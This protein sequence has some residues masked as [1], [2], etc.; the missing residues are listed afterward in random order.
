MS[1]PSL[2]DII[3]YQ[4]FGAIA[5][6]EHCAMI[7]LHYHVA[8]ALDE[9]LR[10][11]EGAGDHLVGKGRLNVAPMIVATKVHRIG[12]GDVLDVVCASTDASSSGEE[13]DEDVHKN[14]FD[15][16]EAYVSARPRNSTG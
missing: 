10:K 2:N 4:S 16:T 11:L 13:E 9:C 3:R 5:A 8:D 12:G 6:Y 1:D 7:R 14:G 15:E